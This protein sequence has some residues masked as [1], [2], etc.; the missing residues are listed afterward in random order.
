MKLMSYILPK[1]KIILNSKWIWL[2]PKKNKLIIIDRNGKDKLEN[3]V[4]RHSD[5]EVLDVRGESINI[6]ILFMSIYR[7]LLT[8]SS[9]YA[10][11]I[12]YIR[13]VG[14]NFAI[15]FIDTGLQL[16]EMISYI[17]ECKLAFVQNGWRQR[18][19]KNNKPD[20]KLSASYYFVH[21]ADWADYA[22][23]YLSANY[24]VTGSIIS[25][26][27]KFSKFE[28]IKKL[29]WISNWKSWWTSKSSNSSN[30][31]KINDKNISID[32]YYVNPE[33]LALNVL[34]LFSNNTNINIEILGRS[35]DKEEYDY[36][37]NIFD[38]FIFHERESYT[39]SYEHVSNDS[40]IVGVDSTLLKEMFGLGY[41]T[42]FFS[43]RSYYI[44]DKSWSFPWPRTDEIHGDFW[45]NIPDTEIMYDVL[46]YLHNVNQNEWN[47]V[48]KKYNGVMHY[49]P[50][51][52]MIR[53]VLKIEGVRIDD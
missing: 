3:H 29:Q 22:K 33:H 40:I 48:L 17:P 46:L 11:T 38:N 44:K 35:C 21:Q 32:D 1:I 43:I 42:A 28:S 39:D 24:V 53:D 10:Y 13:Y 25:N 45:C 47:K 26:D 30:H 27:Y 52:K 6:P 50:N 7:V 23:N 2:L 4:F 19:W 15:T 34:K 14:A 5:F 16:C 20:G 51:N 8:R 18:R 9:K 41:R 37:D 12:T 36:Y 31:I 49:S